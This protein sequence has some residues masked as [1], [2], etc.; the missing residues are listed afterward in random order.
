MGYFLHNEKISL[1]FMTT[2]PWSLLFFIKWWTWCKDIIFSG[3][4]DHM[5]CWTEH[6][7]LNISNSNKCHLLHPFSLYSE[8]WTAPMYFQMLSGWNAVEG[9]TI[10]SCTWGRGMMAEKCTSTGYW[11]IVPGRNLKKKGKQIGSDFC[12]LYFGLERAKWIKWIKLTQRE[13]SFDPS[14]HLELWSLLY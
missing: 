10:H 3:Q 7:P 9:G 6:S 1:L 12:F 11:E 4:N 13:G 14:A 8:I 2:R 5:L